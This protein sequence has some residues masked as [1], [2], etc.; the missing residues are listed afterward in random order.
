MFVLV[1]RG[2]RG[3]SLGGNRS[4][5]AGELD[6]YGLIKVSGQILQ[7]VLFALLDF[8]QD[9]LRHS[10][11]VLSVLSGMNLACR[12]KDFPQIGDAFLRE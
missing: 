4:G 9:R 10:S 2:G 8:K 5:V 12:E 1:V 7:D 6:C 11:V 3:I